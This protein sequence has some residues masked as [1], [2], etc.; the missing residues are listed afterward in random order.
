MQQEYEI[1]LRLVSKS[2]KPVHTPETVQNLAVAIYCA[3]QNRFWRS[4]VIQHYLDKIFKHAVKFNFSNS[5]PKQLTLAFDPVVF[6]KL[7]DVYDCVSTRLAIDAL[8][9]KL[10]SL[11]IRKNL[12]YETLEPFIVQTMAVCFVHFYSTF[13]SKQ[14]QTAN[15]FLTTNEKLV[16]NMDL[17]FVKFKRQ[18]SSNSRLSEE[19]LKSRENGEDYEDLMGFIQ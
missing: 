15:I 7:V 6:Q 12:T 2:L 16:K 8:I 17:Y 14:K 5:V 19:F 10:K 13:Q 11:Q 9:T 18:L 3:D 4:D 1:I